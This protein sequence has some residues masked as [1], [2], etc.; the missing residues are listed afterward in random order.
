MFL[1]VLFFLVPWVIDG[2]G[3]KLGG[4][5]IS[6]RSYLF[7]LYPFFSNSLFEYYLYIA[8]L[9]FFFQELSNTFSRWLHTSSHLLFDISISRNLLLFTYYCTNLTLL[10]MLLA[11]SLN[12]PA[13]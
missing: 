5:F 12:I 6:S 4:H 2:I 1:M 7:S 11:W 13:S 8:R 3:R 10:L 9:L